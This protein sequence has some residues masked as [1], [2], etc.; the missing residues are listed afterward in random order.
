[1]IARNMALVWDAAD[2]ADTLSAY[3]GTYVE[4]E[5]RAEGLVRDLGAFHRFLGAL[6]FSHAAVLNVAEVAR[7]CAARRKTVE[8]FLEILEDLLLAFRV[9]VFARRARRRV[10]AHPKF[11]FADAGVYRALR[12]A[13]PLDRPEEAR[14]AALEGLFAQHL[15]AWI[16]YSRAGAEL[17]FWRT[18]AGGEVDF[19]LYGPDLFW[20]LD[21]K[22]AA[23]VR[24]AD[25]RPLRRFA[26]DYPEARVR[27]AVCAVERRGL[28]E[29]SGWAPSGA[30]RRR[31]VGAGLPRR[32]APA[33]RRRRVPAGRRA[34]AG[35]G[36]GGAAAL[37]GG[38][39][40]G[41]RPDSTPGRRPVVS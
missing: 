15:R 29:R 18:R 19:V 34:A 7:E 1:M 33:D 41:R 22:H 20:A 28:L 14:G 11:Y 32:R 25:L 17:S 3:A 31:L 27:L 8:G 13:G 40:G 35:A 16:D 5:V 39:A 23:R 24:P 6:S 10:T 38:A 26:A 4:Q 2:R 21:V 12:P 30:A 37:S 9:P 36:A